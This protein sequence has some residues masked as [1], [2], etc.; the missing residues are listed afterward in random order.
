MFLI[1]YFLTYDNKPFNAGLKAAIPSVLASQLREPRAYMIEALCVT[2][3]GVRSLAVHEC[4][5]CPTIGRFPNE[6]V[7]SDR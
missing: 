3:R 6:L 2:D 7:W 5:I 1:T 4:T